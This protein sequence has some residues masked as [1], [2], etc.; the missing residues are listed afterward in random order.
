M[1]T[2]VQHVV[3]TVEV[4]R[5]IIQEK[6]NQMTKHIDVPRMQVVVEK[7]A[8]TPETQTIQGT[9]NALRVWAIRLSVK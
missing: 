6:I 2:H 1:N 3:D 8:K 9:L 7:T 4:E 5:H